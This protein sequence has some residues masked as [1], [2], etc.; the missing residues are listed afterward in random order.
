[1]K[2]SHLVPMMPRLGSESPGLG[3]AQIGSESPGPGE[4]MKE[5]TAIR[6]RWGTKSPGLSEAQMGSE[7]PGPGEAYVVTR[8]PGSGRGEGK[9]QIHQVQDAQVGT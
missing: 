5:S 2:Q 4:A 1:M 9:D 8:V 7:S 6:S 3:D